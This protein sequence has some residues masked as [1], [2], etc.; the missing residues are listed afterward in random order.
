M[1]A[2]SEVMRRIGALARVTDEPGRLTRTY[3]SPA[4]REANQLVAGW[5]RQ[6]GMDTRVDVIGNLIGRYA[7][8]RPSAKVFLLGSHLDT[9]R[10]AGK[11]DGPLG[12]LLGL[13]CVEHLNQRRQRLPFAVEV[14]G[15]A[16]EE[17]VRFQSTYL[18][19]RT[20]AGKFA[21]PD[22]K[23]AD[24]NG[25]TLAEAIQTFG[26]LSR[27]AGFQPAVSPISNRQPHGRK[28]AS[29]SLSVPA[30]LQ[31]AEQQ[32]ANLRYE[33]LSANDSRYW[34]N[35]LDTA[36]LDPDRLIG[37]LEAHIEQGPALDTEGLS[38]AVVTGIAGQARYQI[39]FVGR[40]GHAGTTPV[41][42]RQDALCAASEFVLGVEQRAR[43][44]PGLVA[45]V[46]QIQAEPN[47]SNVIPGTVWLTLD[48]RHQEN[49][50]R[51]QA[52]RDL[53]AQARQIA[54]RRGLR[55]Q[56]KQ[57][58]QTGAV[59]CSPSLSR[60]LLKAAQQHQKKVPQIASGAGHDAAVMAGIT[61]TAMLFVRCKAGISHHPDESAHV[62][63]VRVALN[64]MNDFLERLAR[65]HA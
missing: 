12:V 8:T 24:A 60:L 41:A 15:F 53:M 65:E 40:A 50:Q 44:E 23:R 30:D 14:V 51:R 63:D 34:R 61:P 52:E 47:V 25:V 11:F 22:L 28:S 7:G 48:I 36:R 62:R 26:D 29:E 35:R 6:A 56:V 20:L 49:A 3:G 21:L 13:A 54:A 17:G 42:L 4:M 64:T 9:V 37:Y 18:G 59:A 33:P 45:T 57:V 16:D 1:D 31:S 5:M 27:S 58:Q 55:A 32:I 39:T 46:G 43:D 38:V 2:A 10:N 19:S